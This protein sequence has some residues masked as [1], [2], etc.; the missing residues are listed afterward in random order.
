MSDAVSTPDPTPEQQRQLG[1]IIGFCLKNRLVVFLLT[2]FI[3]GMGILVAPFDWE[4][5]GVIRYPIPVD[6]IPDIG[7]NQQIVFVDWPG[8][9]PQD[10]D[11]QITYPLTVSLLGVPRVRTIRSVSMFGFASVYVIFEEGA[12]FYWSRARILEKLA[13]LPA[14]T[15]PE[16]VQPMLGPDATPLG[17]IFWYTLE[18][19]DAE[20]NPA[21]GWDLEE[22]R[23]IQ[24]WY[25]RYWLLS[26]E[27]VAEVASV[28]GYVREYQIDVDP[29]AMR[30]HRVT[31]DDV[32]RAVRSSNLDVGARSIE[33][34]NVE[35]L[36]RGVGF[37]QNLS[38][39]AD[40]VVAVN[41]NVPILVSHVAEVTMG[42]AAR[43]G[44]L[45]KGGSQAVGGVAVARYGSNPLAVIR[46]VKERIEETRESMPSKVLLD[47][48]EV[49]RSE[50]TRYAEDHGFN[51]FVSD[52]PNHSA[53]VTHLRALPREDWPAW[54]NIST[55]TVVP[56]YDRTGLIYETLGT[57]KSALIQQ[58]LICSI[59]VILMVM[60]LRSSILISGMLPLS[61]LLTFIGM[62]LVGVDANIVALSGI[63]IAIGTV[64][65]VG[66][67]IAENLL[68][69]LKEAPPEESRI[70]VLH[71]AAAE[72][73]GAVVTA[74]MTTIV[75]FLPVFTMVGAEGKLF[76]PLAWT[77]TMA[78]VA[79][80]IIA[81]TVLPAAA[82]LLFCTQV[83]RGR[84]RTY[85]LHAL[86]VAAGVTAG[87]LL[88]WWAGTALVLFGAFYLVR[89]MLPEKVARGAPWVSN[90]LAVGFVSVLLSWYWHPLGV[91]LGLTRN[92]IF[93]VGVVLLLL[94]IA[95][96]F[97]HFY[98]RILGAC[99]NHKILFLSL[100]GLITFL[101]AMIWLGPQSIFG[102]ISA[103]YRTE[104]PDEQRAELPLLE[105]F[106]Y[107]L[108]QVRDEEWV[109]R[110]GRGVAYEDFRTRVLWTI[111]RGWDGLGKEFMPPLDE[112]SY[113]YM[114]TTMVHA[115]LGEVLDVMAKQDKAFQ[116]IPEV[117]T[118]V[119][120]LGR[121]ET[122]L[123]PAPVS[124]IETVIIYKPE[125][126]TDRDG[127]R[128]TFQYDRTAN[129]FVRDEDGELIPD[130]HG[131]PYRQWRDHIR[132]PDDIWDEIVK[133]GEITGTTSAP[134]LQP[135]SARI[136]MLQTGMRAPMGIK[137][138]GPSLE[139]IEGFA[140]R[141][142]GLLKEVPSVEPATVVADRIVGKPYLEIVPD[143]GALKRYGV[144]I[145]DFQDVVEIAVGGRHLT[146]TVEGRERFP[147][148]VRY[149]RELRGSIESL[150][151]ILI[152]GAG[153]T[154]IPLAEL[155]EIRY[156]RGPQMIR[157]EDTFLT[158]YIPFDMRPGYAEVDV[159]EE[160]RRYLLEKEE[161]GQLV[162]PR[163]VSYEFSGTYESQVRAMQTLRMILPAALF[164][165]FLIIYLEFRKTIMSLLVFSGIIVAWAGGFIMLW[166]YDQPWF[167]DFTV[168]DVSMRTL[169]QVGT[170]NLSVAV[171]VGFLA[172]FSIATDDGVVMGTYLEQ[173]FR[174][175]VPRTREEVRQNVILAGSRRVRACLM[176]T[177]TTTLAL[178]PVMTS[179]G[180]GSDIMVPMAI[181][182]FG[183][184]TIA[185]IT[186]L[187]V[188]VLYCAIE[189]AKL[190]TQ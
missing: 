31:L 7:E 187:V 86:L 44:A 142:E 135:I 78:S 99:L 3:I 46:N 36:I 127:R 10:I 141:L 72:H 125:Y 130:P 107:E 151:R 64:V 170:I 106:K 27:D 124:M 37:V 59:V 38:D 177:L 90:L 28:G 143:R 75:G 144:T 80:I 164:I 54:A 155:A 158:A 179:I 53:W 98:P 103:D 153:D 111:A 168:F 25:V 30:A 93:V 89:D 76:R 39:I 152:S 166:L 15:L 180:R 35:Y 118:A 42:P 63:A 129:E 184:M 1:R 116:A 114:P 83:E 178:L 74:S 115:S 24:D 123:D 120:K 119:G 159:V 185:I 84:L 149:P 11:D 26:A 73:S 161:S 17:Q 108:A 94:S 82:Y 186:M 8:R 182:T 40:S 167:L 126:V 20:G 16:G 87:F 13:S 68:R 176:T 174:D 18:G 12:D 172:L 33:I 91:E 101:G 50:A 102:D 110:P 150:E 41:D 134:R 43:R 88:N 96:T 157:S 79:S 57:L 19:R 61:I 163:G 51:A 95:W 52:E 140:L 55:V 138:T 146:R 105:R 65:D 62:K 81:L 188:P 70:N 121:A 181:P 169:F 136:V 85:V 45:D 139:A 183:G 112:G 71:R 128:L 56:F 67:V 122:P 9:S 4:I 147:I 29:D 21:G 97:M 190:R 58:V 60:H 162:R 189:E 131:R 171:W 113:L 47:L 2:I 160:A 137:V 175:H 23:T 6:A 49:T 48:E 156:V 154:Q 145:Q 34:N 173:V 132:T 32:S 100:P 77:N 133:A 66:I 109:D 69:H 104:M 22:L 14:D 92:V 117:E 5:E 165:I 148:R